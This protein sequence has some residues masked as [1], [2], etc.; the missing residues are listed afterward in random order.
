VYF[1]WSLQVVT[2][3][4]HHRRREIT[5]PVVEDQAFANTSCRCAIICFSGP[6]P[7]IESKHAAKLSG[8]VFE[9]ITYDQEL[10]PNQLRSCALLR[11]HWSIKIRSVINM[12]NKLEYASPGF[13]VLKVKNEDH[14]I[15]INK[16]RVH[17][18][19]NEHELWL[20]ASSA[21]ICE[22][23]CSNYHK[24]VFHTESC[25]HNK[26]PSSD[27]EFSLPT[28]KRA[29]NKNTDYFLQECQKTESVEAKVREQYE[30]IKA[31]Q[32]QNK[33]LSFDNMMLKWQNSTDNCL[34]FLFR[35]SKNHEFHYDEK[36]F[37][38]D[39][40]VGDPKNFASAIKMALMYY[41]KDR[42]RLVTQDPN[43]MALVTH[44]YSKLMEIHS[45]SRSLCTTKSGNELSESVD[46][47]VYKVGH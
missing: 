45:D 35:L 20:L 30:K 8:L 46:C 34:E 23:R 41:H 26:R 10:G 17:H 14:Y 32:F 16:G 19:I 5:M 9:V 24:T 31:L 4:L 12:L 47:F 36:P 43:V 3:A 37:N 39:H 15:I 38:V 7:F 2:Q 29:Q 27:E 28:P 42:V 25:K 44:I 40:L 22:N 33:L 18:Q 21:K 11:F 6:N 13:K 1:F